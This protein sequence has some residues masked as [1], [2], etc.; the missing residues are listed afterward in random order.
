MNPCKAHLYLCHGSDPRAV[1]DELCWIVEEII[2]IYKQEGKP[3]PTP[4]IR[5]RIRK[6]NAEDC[7]IGRWILGRFNLDC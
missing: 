3:L 4:P 1:F 7:V 6:C 2:E 5:Q